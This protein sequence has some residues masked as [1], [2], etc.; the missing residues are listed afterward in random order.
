MD[1]DALSVIEFENGARALVETSLIA[2]YN[3]QI[4]EIYGT[5]GIILCHDGKLRMRTEKTKDWVEPQLPENM[6]SPL[7]Q[8]T[9]SVLYGKPVL[10]GLKEARE[11]TLMMQ[12]AYQAEASGENAII[13]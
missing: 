10:Y 11:L 1:D 5:K 7:R 8:F 13:Q 9:D 3:P 6:P 2:P 12:C 4:M